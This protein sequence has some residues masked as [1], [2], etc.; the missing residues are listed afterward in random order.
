ML[1]KGEYGGYLV[2]VGVGVGG[3]DH[4]VPRNAHGVRPSVQLVEEERVPRPHRVAERR[5]DCTV[6]RLEAL[7]ALDV[8]EPQWCTGGLERL[9][10]GVKGRRAKRLQGTGRLPGQSGGRAYLDAG[11]GG[12]LDHVLANIHILVQVLLERLE[13]LTGNIHRRA[14]DRGLRTTAAKAHPK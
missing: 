7:G 6:D 3:R 13:H 5:L 14:S 9:L 11:R 4:P 8:R 12:K 2:G 10:L 1:Q